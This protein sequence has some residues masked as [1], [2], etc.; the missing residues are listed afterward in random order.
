M[1]ILN[2]KILNKA[3]TFLLTA[4]LLCCCVVPVKAGNLTQ[5]EQFYIG[6]D[7]I[8]I[9]LGVTECPEEWLDNGSTGNGSATSGTTFQLSTLLDTTTFVLSW[10]LT[11][12]SSI[13]VFFMENT[14][15]LVWLVVSLV[16]AV[17]VYFKKRL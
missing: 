6:D 9:E 12:F 7:L 16:G 10:I 8:T 3:A 13:M 17:F 2:K 1:K 14:A 15:L 4:V 5:I 11:S